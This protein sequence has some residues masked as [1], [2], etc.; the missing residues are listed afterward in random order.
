MAKATASDRRHFGVV[1][2]LGCI[3]CLNNGDGGTPAEIHHPRS[4]GGMGLKSD[5]KAVLPL[6]P[7]HHRS[8][9][10]GEAVHSGRES[11]EKIHGTE[12]ELLVQVQKILKH[13]GVQ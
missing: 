3:V 1:A 11:W 4:L 8:G 5:N 13:G 12:L 9:N 10:I 6:C 2:S 7:F